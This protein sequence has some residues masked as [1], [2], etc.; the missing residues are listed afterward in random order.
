[1]ANISLFRGG[2]PV[3]RPAFCC[4]DYAEFMPPVDTPHFPGTPPY[5]SHADGAR[6]QGFLNLSFPFVPNLLDTTA[7]RWMIPPLQKLSAV[8]DVIQ[9]AW[10]PMRGFVD[11]LHIELTRYD[12][13][14]DGVYV[15]PVA[16]RAVWNFTTEQWEYQANTDF[17][18]DI[19]SYANVT[20]LPLGTPAPESGTPGDPGYTAADSPYLFARFPQSG[21]DLPATFGHNLVARDATGKPTGGLDD[22]YG[23][24]V[25]G[26]KIQAGDAAKIKA[27]W[28]GKFE[29]WFCAK[30]IAFEC[31]TFTG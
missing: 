25:L 14:L 3:F 6:E 18:N 2:T 17:D 23:A 19:S 28:R 16:Q 24:V 13:N 21:T 20:K 22:H 7:H 10:V 15:Q 8:G 26:L 30:F 1:M 4:G 29:L 5:D 12:K 31:H 9:L 27:I 11:S